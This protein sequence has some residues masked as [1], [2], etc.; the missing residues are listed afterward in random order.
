MYREGTL[1]RAHYKTNLRQIQTAVGAAFLKLK[2]MNLG[3]G[4]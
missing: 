3:G 1:F 2:L 4:S